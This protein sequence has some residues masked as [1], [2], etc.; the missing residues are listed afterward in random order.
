MAR[1]RN[2]SRQGRKKSFLAFAAENPPRPLVGAIRRVAW[3]GNGSAVRG[4]RAG[5]TPFPNTLTKC[6]H[7]NCVTV[8]AHIRLYRASR[9]GVPDS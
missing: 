7:Q 2:E 3:Y 1:K 5:A 6:H 9:T 4:C 8:R